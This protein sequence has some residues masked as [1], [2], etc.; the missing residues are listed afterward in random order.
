MCQVQFNRWEWVDVDFVLLTLWLIKWRLH[1]PRLVGASFVAYWCR[2]I[3]TW[4]KLARH[5]SR[6]AGV[7]I[8]RCEE[9]ESMMDQDV[10]EGDVYSLRL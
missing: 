1:L 2:S 5:T 4:W 10:G 9:E 8:G 6:N 7:V 3:G